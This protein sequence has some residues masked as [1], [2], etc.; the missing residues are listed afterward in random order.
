MKLETFRI[1]ETL[2]GGSGLFSQG[3]KAI[4]GCVE[5]R[6]DAVI[7]IGAFA[8]G[9]ILCTPQSAENDGGYEIKA[10]HG[11]WSLRN[12]L[13][14]IRTRGKRRE[15]F[16]TALTVGRGRERSA[17][18]SVT[19][20]PRWQSFTRAR[21]ENLLSLVERGGIMVYKCKLSYLSTA[22]NTILLPP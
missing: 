15:P 13:T 6:S 5:K 2:S 14:K 21:M 19:E 20:R 3:G 7:E 1:A 22:V 18:N 4:G 10:V 8:Y 16:T 11:Q 9:Q 17:A 12:W